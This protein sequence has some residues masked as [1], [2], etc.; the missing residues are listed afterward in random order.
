MPAMEVRIHQ[1]HTIQAVLLDLSRPTIQEGP[2]AIPEGQDLLDTRPVMIQT[3]I[4]GLHLVDM[5]LH[6]VQAP[7]LDHLLALV[8]MD[9]A[10]TVLAVV[11]TGVVGVEEM[12]MVTQVLV[13]MVVM[14]AVAAVEMTILNR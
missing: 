8:I 5:P 4:L 7:V 13:E 6:W 10:E 1:I 14:E 2:A 12:V 3:D 11:V 9:L